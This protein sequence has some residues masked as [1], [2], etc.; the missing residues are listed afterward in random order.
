MKNSSKVAATLIT[1]VF[2]LAHFENA[3]FEVD[4][5]TRWIVSAQ[6]V[7]RF[8][9]ISLPWKTAANAQQFCLYHVISRCRDVYLQHCLLFAA[10]NTSGII[11][12]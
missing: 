9:A 2:L 1:P 4:L 5:Q 7:S 10:I 8:G 12:C 3:L 11:E 6:I